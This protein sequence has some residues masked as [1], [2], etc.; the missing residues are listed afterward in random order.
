LRIR[1]TVCFDRHHPHWTPAIM[2]PEPRLAV[3]GGNFGN[4][5][6]GPEIIAEPENHVDDPLATGIGCALAAIL[7]PLSTCP[8]CVACEQGQQRLR[9]ASLVLLCYK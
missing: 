8:R 9:V 1:S 7:P 2:K 5:I 3:D 4:A 6:R